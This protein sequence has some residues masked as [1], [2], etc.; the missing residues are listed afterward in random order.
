MGVVAGEQLRE[1]RELKGLTVEDIAARLKIPARYVRALEQG[2]IAALPEP[3]FVR[4]YV[5]TYARELGLDG[6]ALVAELAPVEVKAPVIHLGVD[7]GGASARRGAP[8]RAPN[9]R[10]GRRRFGPLLA[11]AGLLIVVVLL[12][13]LA[14]RDRPLPATT[15]AGRT[16]DVPAAGEP[17]A[18]PIPPGAAVVT[19]IRLPPAPSAAVPPAGEDSPAPPPAS[20]PVALP[21]PAPGTAAPVVPASSSTPAAATPS[22]PAEVETVAA[23]ARESAPRRGLY[24]RFRGESWVEVRDADNV[25]LHTSV[26]PAGSVLS[27]EGKAPLSITFNDATAADVWYNGV[28]QVD[29]SGRSRVNR[30]IVGQAPR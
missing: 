14:L 27:L 25:V 28:R 30:I 18:L 7:G 12:L 13:F 20:T 21:L 19:E 24:I 4:G 3:T 26:Q 2:D 29:R 23:A 1:A 6:E 16:P 11:I 8:M 15:P 22:S 17:V 10:A 9:F 5:K